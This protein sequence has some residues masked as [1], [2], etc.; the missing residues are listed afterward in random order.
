MRIQGIWWY[1]NTAIGGEGKNLQATPQL[2][3][4]E[5]SVSMFP[6][7][8]PLQIKV[9]IFSSENLFYI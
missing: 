5:C 1:K 3:A 8:N 9:I 2:A 4:K 6:F 7:S